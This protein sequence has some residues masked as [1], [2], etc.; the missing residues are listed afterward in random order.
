MVESLPLWALDEGGEGKSMFCGTVR[1]A[2][3][4]RREGAIAKE[5]ER[6]REGE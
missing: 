2:V 6:G 4:S 5:R 3:R 1:G